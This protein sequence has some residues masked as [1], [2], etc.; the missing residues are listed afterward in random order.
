MADGDLVVTHQNHKYLFMNGISFQ[1]LPRLGVSFRYAGQGRGV[2]GLKD[3]SIG[4]EVLARI[5][6]C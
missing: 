3:G 5:F 6:P 1:A 4:I 2:G